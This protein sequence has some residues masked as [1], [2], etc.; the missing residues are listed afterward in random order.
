MNK[1]ANAHSF[2]LHC[3]RIF[4]LFELPQ[5]H[6]ER[7]WE[8]AVQHV[9]NESFLL[10]WAKFVCVWMFECCCCKTLEID[11][12][13]FHW[14][15]FW[16][17]HGHEEKKLKRMPTLN[18]VLM[19]FRE[20]HLIYNSY[21]NFQLTTMHELRLLAIVVD[22]CSAST[23][24]N[25]FVARY[26]YIFTTETFVI[27]R[28]FLFINSYFRIFFFNSFCLS[29]FLTVIVK[30]FH[31]EETCSDCPPTDFKSTQSNYKMFENCV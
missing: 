9:N 3:V 5:Q 4:Y 11:K 13:W 26:K 29:V 20:L 24:L 7:Y 6:C 30:M 15:E 2:S 27:Y 25:A 31:R 10:H 16:T 1:I 12:F 14:W 23:C 8:W 22:M 17:K 19:L 18:Q 21:R 28:F